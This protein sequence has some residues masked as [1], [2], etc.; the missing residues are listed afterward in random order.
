VENEG[1][2]PDIEVVD[3]PD[4]WAQGH[5]PSLEKAI[6]YLMNELQKNPPKKVKTPV[7]PKGG[8]PR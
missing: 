8:A 1:V 7:P 6:D 3:R 2:A 4:L 5:D